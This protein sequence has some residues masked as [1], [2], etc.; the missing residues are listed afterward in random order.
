MALYE[1]EA[2]P[3]LELEAHPEG[4]CECEAEGEAF[5]GGLAGLA[6]RALRSPALRAIALGAARS[7]LG[8][9]GGDGEMEDEAEAELNPVRKVY[10][11]AMLEHLAHQAM[12][13]ESEA[14]AGEAF[15]PLIPLVAAKL[16]PLA[17]KGLP[18]MAKALPKVMSTVSR[19]T[20]QL[21][22]GVTNIAR[23]LFRSPH[24]RPLLRTLPSI[25]QR[26]V[27]AIARQAARGQPV[28]ARTALRALAQQTAGLI[29]RPRQCAHALRRS[30]L[31]DRQLHRVV[32]P[33][34]TGA[35][36]ARRPGT[37]SCCGR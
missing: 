21:T 37:C 2:L 18:L 25:A 9:L 15:L 12:Q 26:T 6:T 31:L 8:A 24:T 14:E 1:D 34:M 28:T 36:R 29:A 10:A 32:A 27:G 30:R 5:L 11:D 13:A 35:A 19:L 4:E 17:A 33:V 22:R 20:P 7:A 23:T 16:L 3:E